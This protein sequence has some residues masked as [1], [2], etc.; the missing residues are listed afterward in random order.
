ME[1]AVDGFAQKQW[2]RQTELKLTLCD[3]K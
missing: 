2:Q 3:Q 1:T